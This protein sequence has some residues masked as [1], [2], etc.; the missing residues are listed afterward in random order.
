MAV[1]LRAEWYLCTF[2]E[3]CVEQQTPCSCAQ[4][5]AYADGQGA[6]RE[7]PTVT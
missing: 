2:S 5:M 4:Q 3:A 1:L 7:R 6:G